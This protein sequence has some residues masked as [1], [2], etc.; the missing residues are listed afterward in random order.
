MY[1]SSWNFSV[2]WMYLCLCLQLGAYPITCQLHWLKHGNRHF[3]HPSSQG[4]PPRTFPAPW[5]C[6]KPFHPALMFFFSLQAC[7]WSF[8]RTSLWA[9]CTILKS[10]GGSGWLGE[11]IKSAGIVSGC[12]SWRVPQLCRW[13]FDGHNLNQKLSHLIFDVS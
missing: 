9:I 8:G 13:D 11:S 12:P 1:I 5:L 7:P 4:L 6:S 10:C 3:P 2:L